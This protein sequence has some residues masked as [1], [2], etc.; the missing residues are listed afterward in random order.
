MLG[1]LSI[2]AIFMFVCTTSVHSSMQAKFKQL[3][4]QTNSPAKKCVFERAAF[5]MGPEVTTVKVAEVDVCVNK[6]LVSNGFASDR[7]PY[8]QYLA[9]SEDPGFLPQKAIYGG[10]HQLA[11]LKRKLK[12]D[13]NRMECI[14]LAT[15][16][17]RNAKN[18]DA[19]IKYVKRKEGIT[20]HK[21]SQLDEGELSYL[22]VYAKKKIPKDE[23]EQVAILDLR[24]ERFLISYYKNDKINL[25]DV[26]IGTEDFKNLV[27]KN[28]KRR[29]NAST[30]APLNKSAIDTAILLAQSKIGIPVNKYKPIKELFE[31]EPKIFAIGNIMT[32]RMLPLG[33]Y[34]TNYFNRVHILNTLTRFAKKNTREIAYK[35]PQLGNYAND[36]LTDTIFVYGIFSVF[37][38]ERI[39]VVSDAQDVDG[40][41]IATRYW[42]KTSN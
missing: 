38:L 4:F 15:G 13:C 29:L 31:N 33:N 9:E 36:I 10:F 1:R 8:K 18:A 16:G 23:I 37:D 11:L 14:A 30:A 17:I 22:S 25:F 40:V 7:M 3:D 20:I 42:Q 41:L 24:N 34:G 35:F 26:G 21:V 28:I 27:I 32:E 19:F 6:I 2:I 5:L 39:N 12:I